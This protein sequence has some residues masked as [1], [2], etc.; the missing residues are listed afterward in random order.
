[1]AVGVLLL[2]KAFIMHC[3]TSGDAEDEILNRKL[4]LQR[5]PNNIAIL[6][7]LY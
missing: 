7:C 5:T 6:Y 1:M 4:Q 3:Y 2:D